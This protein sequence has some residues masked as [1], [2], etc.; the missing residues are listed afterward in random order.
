MLFR[1]TWEHPNGDVTVGWLSG[2]LEATIPAIGRD[3]DQ[4]VDPAQAAWVEAAAAAT[5]GV[6]GGYAPVWELEPAAVPAFAKALGIRRLSRTFFAP[7]W[8]P[9]LLT[10]LRDQGEL[11]FTW[12]DP[13]GATISLGAEGRLW[14]D[15][16][17]LADLAARLGIPEPPARREL[18]EVPRDRVPHAAT[19][20][21]AWQPETL[22][23]VHG[24]ARHEA[25]P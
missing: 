10:W 9:V 11:G 5:P 23:S 16:W 8:D 21:G 20:I 7:R 3:G 1:S 25:D 18:T 22:V 17:P 6:R 14:L 19:V 12:S 15:T 2:R 4:P 24:W 13:P